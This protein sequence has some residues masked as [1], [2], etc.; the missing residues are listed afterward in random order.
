MTYLEIGPVEYTKLH[1]EVTQVV[2]SARR[3]AARNVNSIMTAAYWEVGR[4][5][6]SCEQNGQSRA[7]YGQALIARLAD[8]LTRRFGRGFGPANLANM[9]AFY[10]AWP[11]D[12]IF[13]TP[14][15]K[16][17]ATDTR[18]MGSLGARQSDKVADASTISPRCLHLMARF[19]LPWSAYVRLLSLKTKDARAFYETEAL[20]EGWSVRQLDR[21][22]GSQLYERCL[23]S[24]NKAALDSMKSPSVLVPIW[25][26][27]ET[28]LRVSRRGHR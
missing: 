27:D 26:S 21:Q 11:E 20:R 23:L 12:E 5:I 3:A 18:S 8:D 14:S 7:G 19:K 10:S 28:I 22:I 9:R 2:E 15:G 17:V 6:V 4:R 25:A 16:L 1:N 13:Q 24:R